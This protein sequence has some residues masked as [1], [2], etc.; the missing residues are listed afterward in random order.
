M[1]ERR[2]GNAFEVKGRWWL[3]EVSD[4]K[5][6]G[7]LQVGESGDLKLDLD[8]TLERHFASVP[9]HRD[10]KRPEGEFG[11]TFGPPLILGQAHTGQCIT[12]YGV[13][14]ASTNIGGAMTTATYSATGSL[15][16]VISDDADEPL[17]SY[18]ALQLDHLTEWVDR[19]LI[20]FDQLDDG[21]R[22][23]M[24]VKAFNES[25]LTE[26][27]E[28]HGFDIKLRVASAYEASRSPAKIKLRSHVQIELKAENTWKLEKWL[29]VCREIS[30]FFTT[31]IGASVQIRQIHLIVKPE[32]L[33]TKELDETIC[34]LI[35][36]QEF[37]ERS[38]EMLSSEMLVPFAEV[39]SKLGECLSAW[40]GNRQKLQ[41]AYE[42]FESIFIGGKQT[43]S[44]AILTL[45]Q[46]FEVL[47]RE[48]DG[49]RYVADEDE[50]I[51]EIYSPLVAS[52]PATVASDHRE[53][54]KNKLKFAN[55]YSLRKRLTKALQSL[56]PE[57]Q[58]SLFGDAKRFAQSITDTRNYLTHRDEG[59]KGE[60]VIADE[61]RMLAAER[62]RY[63]LQMLLLKTIG[64]AP[65]T[66]FERIKNNYRRAWVLAQED[67]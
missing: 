7:T 29:D 2:L 48:E 31:I 64:F 43:P 49:G 21:S 58:K 1:D 35:W 25:I 38:R 27:V 67:I 19:R 61:H 46:A 65:L 66:V 12:L 60:F 34:S 30:R 22:S 53:A 41:S 13:Q 62:L 51:A 57:I 4:N 14:S 15:F 33:A 24:I 37:R 9:T 18:C 10:I 40:M 39:G 54:I 26:K 11:R 32:N 28:S 3:P 8:G 6:T 20:S 42:L 50:Y 44:T 17:S 45:S 56:D 55:A 63:L 59:S 23:E 47:H 36:P 52:I 5:V 16:G